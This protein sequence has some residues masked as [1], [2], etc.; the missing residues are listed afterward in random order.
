MLQSGPTTVDYSVHLIGS[1]PS[2]FAGGLLS[3]G[4]WVV[5]RTAASRSRGVVDIRLV[6]YFEHM[7]YCMIRRNG[8]ARRGLWHPFR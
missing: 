7:R 3:H 4:I 5:L 8:D 1:E 2:Y 6:I